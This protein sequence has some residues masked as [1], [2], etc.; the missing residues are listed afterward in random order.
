MADPPNGPENW[1]TGPLYTFAEA[2]RL[3]HVSTGTVR[4]W[5]LG[6]KDD[7]GR[8][9]PPLIHK[10]END[11]AMVSFLQLIEVVVAGKFRKAERVSLRT[12]RQAHENAAAQWKIDYPFAYLHLEVLG[13]HIVQ[14]LREERF[15]RSLQALDNPRQWTLPGLVVETVRQMEYDTEEFA[16]R[17]YPVG[18]EYPIV[19]DP[20]VTSG[21]P[22]IE[23]RGVTIEVI[24]KR[25]KA[26]QKL[27]FI[28]RDFEL[29][30]DIVEEALRYAKQV[31]A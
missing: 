9:I 14:R 4:N 10:S 3:A 31:A 12:V 23:H 17:W 18:K 27:D 22:T 13:G 24:H 20:K 11:T 1:R 30:P 5:L 8:A 28:A 6:Y 26:G 7:V 21:V 15:G 2:G 29:E 25:F 16:V 19:V